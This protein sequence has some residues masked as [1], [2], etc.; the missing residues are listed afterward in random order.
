MGPLSSSTS[1]KVILD[2]NALMT[3]EQ[4]GVDIFS[5]LQRLGFVECLVPK[6]VLRELKLLTTR[7]DKGLDKTAAR[8]GLGLAEQCK[9]IDTTVGDADRA[10]EEL[11]IMEN[12][13]V[14]T[15]D[16]VLKKRLSSKGITVIYLR[17]G[18]YLEAAKKEY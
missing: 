16:R 14:F 7:A 10:I 17:Q 3:P 18:R 9:I 12:A 4:F 8:V 15:N 11:A 1:T 6:P 2:T 13:S 5:E